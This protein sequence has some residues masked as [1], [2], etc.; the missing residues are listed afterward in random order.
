[1]EFCTAISCMDG[2]IQLPVIKYLQ[3][4]F[5]AKYVDLITEPGPNLILAEQT[6]PA[7][8]SSILARVQISV[9][10][11]HS[12]GIAVIGHYNCAGNPATEEKQILHIEE[13]VNFIRRR[14]EEV[15]VIGLW[16]DHNWEVR[17]TGAG[18]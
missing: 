13:S 2:R 8:V 5:R 10:H 14:Y 1:M 7:L 11:H 6:E 15:E 12:A 17:E 4:R 18:G 9:G 16:V 3:A